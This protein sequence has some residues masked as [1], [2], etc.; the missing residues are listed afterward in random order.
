MPR[1]EIP[2]RQICEYAEQIANAAEFL[3]SNVAQVQCVPSVLLEGSLAVE[4]YLK[5]LSA[6]TVLHPIE[7]CEVLQQVTANPR[8]GHV[9]DRLFDMIEQ[10][11]R[12]ELQAAYERTPAIAGVTSLRDAL[13]RYNE[14]FVDIRYIFER[15]EA[16]NLD[17]GGLMELVRFCRERIPRLPMRYRNSA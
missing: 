12:D 10:P 4:L 17:I 1:Y 2:N 3:Y 16:G 9:L 8:R 15:Q 7:G 6:E 11:I 14:T 5:S 13:T